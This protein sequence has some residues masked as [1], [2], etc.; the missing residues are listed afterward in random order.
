MNTHAYEY[1]MSE[2]SNSLGLL[3]L[4]ILD[5]VTMATLGGDEEVIIKVDQGTQ[6]PY[7]KR[8]LM[9]TFQSCWSVQ[10]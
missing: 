7:E 6:K 4:H 1:N 5:T 8:S 3:K 2:L 10:E 9:S